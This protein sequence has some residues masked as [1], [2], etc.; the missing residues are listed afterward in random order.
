MKIRGE[1]RAGHCFG[2]RGG[3]TLRLLDLMMDANAEGDIFW[4]L[5]EGTRS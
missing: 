2:L 4:L 3:L 1:I 5:R